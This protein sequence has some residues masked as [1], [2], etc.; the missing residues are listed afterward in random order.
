[1]HLIKILA[2][3]CAFLCINA[4]SNL[5]QNPGFDEPHSDC[6]T[7]LSWSQYNTSNPYSVCPGADW[8]MVSQPYALYLSGSG[9]AGA[10]QT[11]DVSQTEV[12]TFNFSCMYFFTPLYIYPPLFLYPPSFF[13]PLSLL[14][15]FL[16]SFSRS[17]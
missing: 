3:T 16:L 17:C 11:V 6:N 8:Y 9:W 2:F 7:T 13:P 5:L 14:V 12:T 10:V 15:L 1:M 4:A